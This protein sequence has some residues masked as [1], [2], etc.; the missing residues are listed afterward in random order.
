[1]GVARPLADA[2]AEE[3]LVASRLLGELAFELGSDPATLRRHMAS[4]QKIDLVTQMQLAVVD[5]L[6]ISGDCE[7]AVAS[8]KLEAT[9]SRLHR[10]VTGSPGSEE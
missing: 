1:M 4:L 2:L 3:L 10:A 7:D 8:V 6:R 9:A 5:M